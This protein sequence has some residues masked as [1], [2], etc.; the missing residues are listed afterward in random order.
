MP[1]AYSGPSR[2][3]LPDHYDALE[4]RF[5]GMVEYLW[6]LDASVAAENSQQVIDDLLNIAAGD[7]TADGDVLSGERF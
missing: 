6:R 4:R 5:T 2:P 7:E 3:A 1:Y